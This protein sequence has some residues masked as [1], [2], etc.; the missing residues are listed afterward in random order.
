MSSCQLSD[1]RLRKFRQ[2]LNTEVYGVEENFK[3]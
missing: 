2:I 3:L 1:E